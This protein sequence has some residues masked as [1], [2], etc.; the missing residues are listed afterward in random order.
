[1]KPVLYV[2]NETGCHYLATNAMQVLVPR[3]DRN[4]KQ[5]CGPA[6]GAP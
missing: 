4:G 6:G 1:M 3:M 2:D 5:V